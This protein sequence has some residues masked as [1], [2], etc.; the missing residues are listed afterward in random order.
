LLIISCSWQLGEAHKER[1]SDN[2]ETNN[3]YE[4]IKYKNGTKSG[5]K[6]GEA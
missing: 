2:Y 1:I 3:D 5:S 6:L 4:D